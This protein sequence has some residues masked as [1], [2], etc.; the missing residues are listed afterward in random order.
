MGQWVKVVTAVAGV[1][2]VVQ[3]QSL[4]PWNF[5]MPQVQPIKKKKKR[6]RKDMKEKYLR[7]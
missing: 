5:H 1:S 2:A 3:V 7:P 4:W 6:E